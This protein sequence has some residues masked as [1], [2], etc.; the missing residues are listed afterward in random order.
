MRIMCLICADKPQ[1]TFRVEGPGIIP[2]QDFPKSSHAM[3]LCLCNAPRAAYACRFDSIRSALILL[4]ASVRIASW[5][6]KA[7][8]LAF[9]TSTF[10]LVYSMTNLALSACGAIIKPFFIIHGG[11]HILSSLSS[12]SPRFVGT[13]L[14]FSC[15]CGS[16]FCTIKGDIIRSGRS[17]R[18]RNYRLILREL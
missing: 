14:Y 6:F 1:R 2:L 9:T 3:P 4:I 11:M 13:P 5:S 18:A 7:T 8:P 10:R 17:S 15:G 12:S 16:I